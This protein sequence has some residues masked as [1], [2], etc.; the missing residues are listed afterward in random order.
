MSFIF[1]LFALLAVLS[2]PLGLIAA[3][4]GD[5][6]TTDFAD[7]IFAATGA[8]PV[9]LTF[10][11]VSTL[12]ADQVRVIRSAIE[13]QLRNLGVKFVEASPQST[14]VRVTLSQNVRGWVWIA[15]IV[16]GASQ[17]VVMV[18]VPVMGQA[19]TPHTGTMA[20]HKQLL[21]TSDE[22][23]LDVIQLS[24]ANTKSLV[25]L[26]P[27]HVMVFQSN[28][29]TW[30]QQQKINLVR[31]AIMPRDPRGHLVATTDHL[32]DV[33]LPGAVCSSGASMPLVINCRD[34]DDFWPLGGQNAYFNSSRN[35]FSGLLR[36]GFGKQVSPFY[37]AASVKIAERDLWI[38]T[39]IDGQVR[40]TDGGAEQPLPATQEW[41]S[42]IASLH[43][44]CGAGTQIIA[45]SDN[46]STDDSVRAYEILNHQPSRVSAPVV[47]GGP[48]I[49][50]WS[51][52]SASTVMAAVQNTKGSYEAYAIELSCN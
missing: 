13:T 7:R 52:P 44:V 34:A 2:L 37:S 39:G 38:F 4:A 41:G 21:F 23:I 25:A 40:W 11:N 14:T 26:S 29:S 36:P 47:F 24:A 9:T 19:E 51:Q 5:A 46:H 12:D 8:A 1:R 10:R 22:P 15:E 31:N 6:P 27:E 48:I 28:G 20:L 32:F 49:S 50:L 16:Q 43:S 18:S 35:Y 33:Y 30:T 45:S 3:T 17:K 42:D